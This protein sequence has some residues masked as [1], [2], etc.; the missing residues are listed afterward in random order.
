LRNSKGARAKPNPVG[1]SQG[2]YAPRWV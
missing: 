2:V 1:N